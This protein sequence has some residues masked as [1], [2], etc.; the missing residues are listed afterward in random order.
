[1]NDTLTTQPVHTSEALEQ[2]A[3]LL[4]QGKDS[5]LHRTVLDSVIQIAG[6]EQASLLI[7]GP[8]PGELR[9][10]TSQDATGQARDIR[11]TDLPMNV[12][13][14]ALAEDRVQFTRSATGP[15]QELFVPLRS[16][17]RVVGLLYASR[18]ARTLTEVDLSLL[19][20]LANL[21]AA[22]LDRADLE[23]ALEAEE[24]ARRE[25]V[26]LTTHQLR[27][28]LTSISGYTDLMLSGIAGPLTERQEQF[29]RTVQRNVQRMSQLIAD[30]SDLNRIQDGRL[31]L[32]ITQVDLKALT[33]TILEEQAQRLEAQGLD[34]QLQAPDGLPAARSD[35]PSIRRVFEK[36]L[37]NAI[38]YTPEGGSLT[39]GIVH[40][41][42]LLQVTVADDGIGIGQEDQTQLYVPFF[43]SEA[44]AVREHAGWGL[45]LALAKALLQLLEGDLW[46]ESELGAGAAFHFTLPV[47]SA[48]E[49]GNGTSLS[50]VSSSQ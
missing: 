24:K 6:A 2:A 11:A 38:R 33:Q 45:S 50:P 27:V 17:G 36:I 44:E 48:I 39:V 9:I 19:Q 15:A 37:D 5:A 43:R 20:S 12:A 4:G 25:F 16:G 47:G 8:E 18:L 32:K 35:E 3:L 26:S 7:H 42:Q 34:L 30:L 46:C 22:A 31:P 28:P 1:M 21:A 10:V 41:D 23:A 29:M 49:P 13:L 40:H 14:K